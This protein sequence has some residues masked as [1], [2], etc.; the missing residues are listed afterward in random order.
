MNGMASAGGSSKPLTV[1]LSTTTQGN[2]AGQSI[3][4]NNGITITNI[5]YKHLKFVSGSTWGWGFY[6]NGSCVVGYQSSVDK[7]KIYDISS[8][9]SV[10]IQAKGTI[11]STSVTV[12]L[13]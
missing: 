2:N 6:L 8:A 5:G 11:N 13:Y 3:D 4:Q 9:S 7:N 12:T 1:T 10:T